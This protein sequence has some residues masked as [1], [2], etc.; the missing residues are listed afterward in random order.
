MEATEEPFQRDLQHGKSCDVKLHA[1][2]RS[3]SEGAYKLNGE[4]KD[5]VY[6]AV[7]LEL[8]ASG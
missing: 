5:L 7:Q 3:G 1:T 6:G 4:G 2:I 8:V